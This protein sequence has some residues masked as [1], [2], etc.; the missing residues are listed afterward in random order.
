MTAQVHKFEE[1]SGAV[2]SPCGKFRYRLWR[3]WDNSLPRVLWIMLNPSTADARLDD[4]TIAKCIAFAKL[5]GY[6]GIEVVNLYAYRTSSPK[7]LK[8][9][10]YPIGQHNDSTIVALLRVIREDGGRVVLAWGAH[11]QEERATWLLEHRWQ[12]GPFYYLHQNAGGSPKHP[13]YISYETKLREW[14]YE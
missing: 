9:S 14:G 2:I 5:W 7:E 4:P 11:A 6:G 3:R 8:R 12:I 1:R 13:L 10:G